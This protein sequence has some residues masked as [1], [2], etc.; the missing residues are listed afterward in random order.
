M[1]K[2]K[3]SIILKLKKILGK[4]FFK[5]EILYARE[6]SKD[7]DI[8][9]LN[10]NKEYVTTVDPDAVGITFK[11][12]VEQNEEGIGRPKMKQFIIK[13]NKTKF[14]IREIES[15]TW[16]FLPYMEYS[17][18]R[19]FLNNLQIVEDKTKAISELIRGNS[20]TITIPENRISY[21]KSIYLNGAST[22]PYYKEEYRD[23]N[24]I[25]EKFN[26]SNNI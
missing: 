23:T 21:L 3:K 14:T 15:P 25:V 16:N 24:Y 26:K 6:N 12:L 4:K 5:S 7:K 2:I 9:I 1:K 10:V 19:D 8:D 22:N 17:K 11:E 13:K 18:I 20:V